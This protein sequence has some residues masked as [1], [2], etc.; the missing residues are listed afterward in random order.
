MDCR[1]TT[2][3][4]LGIRLEFEQYDVLLIKQRSV[5]TVIMSSFGAEN[6][7]VQYEEICNTT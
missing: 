5:L 4:K 7:E 3:L 6:M 2:S 1:T